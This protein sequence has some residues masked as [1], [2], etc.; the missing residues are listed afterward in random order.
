M[1]KSK[2]TVE[3]YK[4]VVLQRAILICWALLFVCFTVKIFGGNY[5]AIMVNSPQFV[6]FCQH[7]DSNIVIYGLMG[8]V[9][10]LITYALFYLALLRQMWFTKRQFWIYL[11][12]VLV[13]CVIRVV[14]DAEGVYSVIINSFNVLQCFILPLV[15]TRPCK[16]YVLRIFVGNVLNF[17]FQFIAIITKNIGIKF[18]TESSL[19]MLIFT[20]D[21]YIMLALYYLYSNR[22]ETKV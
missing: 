20:I 1:I 5:F 11:V 8:L 2:T 7:L 14:F 9:S 13:S 3:N 4:S 18:I 12:S 17:V 15:F 21:V 16:P 10:S 19:Q 22:K 6:E